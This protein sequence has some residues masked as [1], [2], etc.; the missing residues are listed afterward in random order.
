MRGTLRATAVLTAVLTGAV[1]C[2]SGSSGGN[3]AQVKSQ[4]GATSAAVVSTHSSPAGTYLT[5]GKGRTLYLWTAD[6]GSSSTCAGP[7]VKVWGPYKTSGTPKVSGDA[8]QS[9]VGSTS[10]SDGSTQVTY[11]NH[12]L[13]YYEGDKSAGAMEGQGSDEFGS[14]WWIVGPDGSAITGSGKGSGASSSS[15]P[16]KSSDSWG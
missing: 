7:C 10:R 11:A 8:Q 14:K 5:D 12:P 1:A 3:T 9:M 6:T 16:S 13:Y 15:S 4:G 2:G